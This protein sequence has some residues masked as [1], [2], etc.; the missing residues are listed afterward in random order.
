MVVMMEKKGGAKAGSPGGFLFSGGKK[1]SAVRV[2]PTG[3]GY[4]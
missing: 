2:S 1:V 4:L 3:V